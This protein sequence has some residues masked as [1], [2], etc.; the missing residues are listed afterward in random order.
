[1]D[2]KNSILVD[3]F[4]G[5]TKLYDVPS[6]IAYLGFT[7]DDFQPLI[8]RGRYFFANRWYCGGIS[9]MSDCILNPNDEHYTDGVMI[10]M[11]GK[12]CR[13]F[14]QNGGSFDKIFV[15]CV[16]GDIKPTRVDIAYD[17]ID[18]DGKG[19]IDIHKL[20]RY[21]IKQRFVTKWGSGIVTDSFKVNGND[22]PMVH[23]LTV[24]FGCNASNCMLR[25]Y[26]KAQE[27]GGLDYHWVRSE[28][29]FRRERAEELLRQYVQTRDIGTL[30]YGV[31]K[32]Y[33]RF[34]K[35]DATRRERCSVVGWWD[36]FL[37]NVQAV[38]LFTPH[39]NDYN[40]EKL[41]HTVQTMWGN[42]IE[43]LIRAEG[44]EAF[45]KNISSRKSKLTVD[46]KQLL[47]RQCSSDPAAKARENLSLEEL[48][49]DYRI[50]SDDSDD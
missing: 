30:Y 16:A 8:G 32:N 37:R 10:E 3:W 43:T 41:N 47:A 21:T 17:D 19:L 1:M 24:Q 13:Q 4:S 31:L 18:E 50:S 36:N 38:R 23:A 35:S 45:V 42:S 2:N 34:I 29:V 28:L 33:L 14:E 6:L 20:A 11:S 15:D 44:V 27:R 5:T 39:D 25:I 26:D 46:Q 12:G 9:I 40:L 22:E 7:M 49:A 48:F